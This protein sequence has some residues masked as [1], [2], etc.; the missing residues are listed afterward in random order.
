MKNSQIEVDKSIRQGKTPQ[1]VGSIFGQVS[2]LVTWEAQL[3]TTGHYTH[4]VKN[5]LLRR[6]CTGSF[7]QSIGLPCTH[8]FEAI[9]KGPDPYEFSQYNFHLFWFWSNKAWYTDYR[10]ER[11]LPLPPTPEP[12]NILLTLEDGM[13]EQIQEPA[14]ASSSVDE[15][16]PAGTTEETEAWRQA[17]AIRS[18][19]TVPAL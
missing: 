15:Q 18:E 3:K 6:E 11:V 9:L 12:R 5:G 17:V 8:V 16:P 14:P 2:G 7:R 1:T 10:P 19:P 13:S 4:T